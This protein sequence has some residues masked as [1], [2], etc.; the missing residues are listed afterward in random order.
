MGSPKVAGSMPVAL[1]LLPVTVGPQS[2]RQQAPALERPQGEMGRVQPAVYPHFPTPKH[3]S[4]ASLFLLGFPVSVSCGVSSD[5]YCS[6]PRLGVSSVAELSLKAQ[7]APVLPDPLGM[8][9]LPERLPSLQA[10]IYPQLRCV[11]ASLRMNM[12][13]ATIPK[14]LVAD[15][16]EKATRGCSCRAA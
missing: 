9:L 10:L 14:D 16:P 12:W 13:G 8:K 6:L 5:C 2:T 7:P 4:S 15:R 11:V 1:P 3:A